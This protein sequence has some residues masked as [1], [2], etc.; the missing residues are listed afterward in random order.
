[1]KELAS[2]HPDQIL[3]SELTAEVEIDLRLIEAAKNG[4]W[5]EVPPV[6]IFELPKYSALRALFYPAEFFMYNGHRRRIVAHN[7]DL[8]LKALLPEN[9][10]D[11]HSLPAGER[12]RADEFQYMYDLMYRKTREFLAEYTLWDFVKEDENSSEE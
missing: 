7:H 12:R 5:D 11:L 1:M 2:V 3:P 6:I 8:D 4:S 9:L 10:S